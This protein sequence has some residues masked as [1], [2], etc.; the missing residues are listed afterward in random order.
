VLLATVLER[1]SAHLEVKRDHPLTTR[2][3]YKRVEY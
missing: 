3:Y 1:V 2:R